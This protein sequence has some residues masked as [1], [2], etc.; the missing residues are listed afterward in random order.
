M[1]RNAATGTLL[2]QLKVHVCYVCTCSL[3]DCW[4]LTRLPP[5]GSMRCCLCALPVQ[6]IQVLQSLEHNLAGNDCADLRYGN[7]VP[8]PTRYDVLLGSKAHAFTSTNSDEAIRTCLVP[9]SDDCNEPDEGAEEHGSASSHGAC[10]AGVGPG[11]L[12]S[13]GQASSG[14]QR[15][16]SSCNSSTG[17]SGGGG[18]P[19]ASSTCAC[20]YSSP[21]ALMAPPMEP[22]NSTREGSCWVPITLLGRRG[23][24]N[25]RC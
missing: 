11:L 10:T 9:A 19:D 22:H 3:L 13:G 16:C 21:Q 23:T 6:V 2:L 17:Q 5:A 8:P 1:R 15:S 25:G 12:S 7:C 20:S 18:Q 4:V 14:D 24:R